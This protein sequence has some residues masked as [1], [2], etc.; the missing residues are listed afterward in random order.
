MSKLNDYFEK[1]IGLPI[2]YH[3]Y[4]TYDW[5]SAKFGTI[6]VD[7]KENNIGI[8]LRYNVDQR[9]PKDPFSTY[10]PSW[11][12]LKIRGDE[13]VIVEE[14]SRMLVDKIVY[15]KYDMVEGKLYYTI[16]GK[17]KV[18]DATRQNNFV[19][20]LDKGEYIPGNHHIKAL[21]NNTIECSPATRTLKELDSKHIILNSTQLEQGCE[22]DVYYIER[23]DIKN[24]VPRIFNQETEPENPESGDFWITSHPSESMKQKLP[25]NLFVRYDYNSMQLLVLLKTIIGST[26]KI[27]KDEV[28]HV[29]QV[30]NR[31]WSTFRIPIQYNETFDVTVEGTND[32]YLDNS[33]TK[34]IKTT[35]K[36]DI[37]LLKQELVKDTST[38]YLQGDSKCNFMIMSAVDL[39]DIKFTEY[40]EGKYKATLPR[41]LKSYFIDIVSRKADKLQTT[42]KSILIRAKDPVEIPLEITNKE[43]KLESLSSQYANVTVTATYNKEP[44]MIINSNYPDG[45]TLVNKAIN[46]DKVNFN[47][48]INLDNGQQYLSFI[49][50]D[51]NGNAL[52]RVVSVRLPK[53]KTKNIPEEYGFIEKDTI[54]GAIPANKYYT[55]N[56]KKYVKMYII[57]LNNSTLRLENLN[58]YNT[59][60]IKFIGRSTVNS[61]GYRKYNY[62]IPCDTIPRNLDGTPKDQ[63][64]WYL[65]TPYVKFSVHIEDPYAVDLNYIVNSPILGSHL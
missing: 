59:A 47:Y 6:V 16:N 22:I 43:I 55:L 51:K 26:I 36:V 64:N 57:A 58:E 52:S 2:I 11:V 56:G 50:D 41:Q 3:D 44:H 9:D 53:R 21:I 1:T 24:P 42:I 45:I 13:T 40:E 27:N 20:E 5:N 7:P 49:A 60:T 54:S 29:N 46:N 18:S 62:L 32:W 12:A 65:D 23:Y 33:V 28:E 34:H 35:S 31:S 63:T 4:E 25:L 19:F 14:S 17:S 38:I 48:R 61:Y 15:V 37:A 10:G 39:S 8:K 30:V